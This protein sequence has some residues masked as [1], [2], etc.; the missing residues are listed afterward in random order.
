MSR[1]A[2]RLRKRSGTTAEEAV[3]GYLQG[4]GLALVTR[5]F[6]SRFGEIDLVMRDGDTLVFVEVRYRR[7][8]AI[9][10][11]AESVDRHKQG[12]LIR[13]AEYFLSRADSD[14]LPACRFDV[15]AVTGD[16]RQPQ[17][18]WIPDAFQA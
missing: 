4:R 18:Q 3:A 14:T 2:D 5:N 1:L 10:G 15:V 6:R 13:A 11:A 8:G 7:A 12:R 16:L 17:L 9:I